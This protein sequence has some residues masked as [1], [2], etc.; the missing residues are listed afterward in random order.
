MKPTLVHEQKPYVTIQAFTCEIRIE[1]DD[2]ITYSYST[3]LITHTKPSRVVARV[4][5]LPTSIDITD[6]NNTGASVTQDTDANSLKSIVDNTAI[7][8]TNNYQNALYTTS[9]Y[10]LFQLKIFGIEYGVPCN[11]NQHTYEIQ[12]AN[13]PQM[14]QINTDNDLNQYVKTTRTTTLGLDITCVINLELYY[15][16]I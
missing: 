12:T 13:I 8:V 7:S 5:A 11:G 4:F 15:H 3:P 10:G 14:I 2:T 6:L 16:S 9:S 1:T